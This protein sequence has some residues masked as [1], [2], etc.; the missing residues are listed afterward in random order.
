MSEPTSP[1]P[2]SR[3]S[4]RDKVEK[5]MEKVKSFT[6]NKKVGQ[7]ASDTDAKIKQDAK[8]DPWDLTIATFILRSWLKAEWRKK[9][10]EKIPSK[11]TRTFYPLKLPSYWS[12]V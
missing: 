12:K 8:G 10:R 11:R 9:R 7:I 3:S 6:D 5:M 2:K 1:K 4:S